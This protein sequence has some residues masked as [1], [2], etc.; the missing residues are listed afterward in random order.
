M[1]IYIYTPGGSGSTPNWNTV[2]GAGSSLSGSHITDMNSGDWTINNYNFFE[3]GDEFATHG[4]HCHFKMELDILKLG[5]A[6]TC[7]LFFDDQASSIYFNS[8]NNQATSIGLFFDLTA[9][10]YYF[11]DCQNTYGGTRIIIDDTAKR[12]EC[13]FQDFYFQDITG[14]ATINFMGGSFV[15][16]T[17]GGS[18]SEHLVIYVNGNKRKI[19]LLYN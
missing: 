6:N 4:E 3:I 8:T 14:T 15:E 12:I 11:G 13:D 2:M 18:A 5:L 10:Q 16:S 7:Y 17:A 9:K 19:Q 1:S